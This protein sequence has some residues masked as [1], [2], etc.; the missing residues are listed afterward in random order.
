[1]SYV[2][3]QKGKLAALEGDEVAIANLKKKQREEFN[4][5]LASMLAAKRVKVTISE[6]FS[7]GYQI[8]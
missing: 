3:R 1:M 5:R 4:K 8:V 7:G 6:V 2:N